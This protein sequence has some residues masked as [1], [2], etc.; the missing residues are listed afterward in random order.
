MWTWTWK[1]YAHGIQF[2]WGNKYTAK[3]VFPMWK[4]W[5]RKTLSYTIYL[6]SYYEK[7]MFSQTSLSQI[8]FTKGQNN[9]AGK[10]QKPDFTRDD[11]VPQNYPSLKRENY[12]PTLSAGMPRPRTRLTFCFYKM[13]TLFL[14][15]KNAFSSFPVRIQ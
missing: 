7:P 1:E 12:G 15:G 8:L 6:H 14:S 3:T 13:L 9:K 5:H 11:M 4:C 10:S 2:Q